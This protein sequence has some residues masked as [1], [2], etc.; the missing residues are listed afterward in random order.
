MAATAAGFSVAF[1]VELALLAALRPIIDPDAG[2]AQPYIVWVA[3]GSAI[4]TAAVAQLTSYRSAHRLSL[5]ALAAAPLATL[6]ASWILWM[7]AF[8]L[9]CDGVDNPFFNLNCN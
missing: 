1:A 4:L 2:G 6:A 8:I 5:A 9:A 7:V 3:V